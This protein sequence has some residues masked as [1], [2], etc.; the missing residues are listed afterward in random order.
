VPDVIAYAVESGSEYLLMTGMPGQ[1]G[2]DA[3]RHH[4]REVATALA[5]ALKALH[6]QSI[7]A[8][9][10]DHPVA[11]EIQRAHERLVAGL[12]D[13]DDFDD[14]RAGRTAEELFIDL[15]ASRPDA[16][17]RAL[18]HGDATLENVVFDEAWSVGFVDCGRAGVADPYRDL[19]LAARSV[20]FD[21][22]REW[23]GS[24][25]TEYGIPHPD[26]R[27]L[28]FYRLLDEFF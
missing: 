10:F 4:P 19:A 5:H 27:K 18:T 8:C 6:A 17:A 12:V 23:V 20:E 11:R 9:P 1:N 3:G 14:E 7:E 26:E 28:A 25:F 15:Q 13:E 22:G 21:L 24:F 16:E 2:V